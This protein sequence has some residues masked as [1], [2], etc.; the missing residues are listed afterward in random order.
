VSQVQIVERYRNWTPP[1]GTRSAVARLVEGIPERYLLGLASVVLTN[2]EGAPRHQRRRKL[3][4]KRRKVSVAR[5]QGLYHQAWQGKPPSI[6]LLVDNIVRGIPRFL[7]RWRFFSDV[8]FGSVLFH[9]IGH[10]LHKTQA[11]EFRDKENVADTWKTR[12]LRPYIRTRYRY[13]LPFL[14]LVRKI[15]LVIAAIQTGRSYG[16]LAS[17]VSGT[18]RDV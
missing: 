11:P 15:I 17:E 6:E 9:E 8:T 12:L 16:S 3:W 2:S 7:L 1:A 13:V 18:K 5:A 4:L 14:P 10:H